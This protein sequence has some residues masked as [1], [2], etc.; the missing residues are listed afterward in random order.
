MSIIIVD[1][2]GIGSWTLYYKPTHSEAIVMIY[3]IPL[4][5]FTNLIIAGIMYF[6]KKRYTPFFMLNG[7]ISSIMLWFFFTLYTEI[8]TLTENKYWEFKAYNTNYH[9]HYTLFYK[10]GNN[11][12]ISINLGNG[13][14]QLCDRG[15]AKVQ[16][17]TLYFFSIDSTTQYYL[18]KDT[19]YNFKYIDKIK[20]KKTCY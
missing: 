10:L 5:L 9:I 14:Y 3:M 6:I 18:Y 7:A 1:I 8:Q 2:I 19:L 16:N 20:V 11:Y 17:D 12:D 4:L 13:F 15:T